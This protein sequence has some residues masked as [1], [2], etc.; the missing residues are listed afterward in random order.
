[1]TVARATNNKN[2]KIKVTP[3]KLTDYQKT[4]LN[5]PQ[6]FSVVEA[7]TKTGKTFSHIFWLFRLAHGLDPVWYTNNVK[8]GQNYWWIAPV[9]SQ[10]KIAFSR[11]KRIIGNAPG[12]KFNL[13]DLIVITPKQTEIHFKS[14]DNPDNLYGEDV[15]GVVFDEF[16]RAK[17]SAW[18]AL[19]STVTYTKAPVK[20]IGNYTGQSNW[21]HKLTKKAITDPTEYAAFRV[22]A[23]DA[24]KAGILDEKEIDQA[25]QDLPLSIFTALYLAE[26]VADDSVLFPEKALEDMFSN[27]FVKEIGQKYITADIALHGSDRFVIQVWHG[28]VVIAT[29]VVDKCNADEVEAL[30]REKAMLHGV[31]QR[32]IAY[33]ADG[34]GAFLK[35]YLKSAIPFNNGAAPIQDGKT[36]VNY[37]HLKAQ[38]FYLLAK[39][40]QEN[41]IYIK[42]TE[43]KEQIILE[44]ENIRK[45]NSDQDGKLAV[46]PK[47]AMKELL[48]FSPDFAESL[49]MRMAFE[50][51]GKKFTSMM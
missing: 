8:P 38:C 35:G 19:R 42:S 12:Y 6:R 49:M 18:F 43:F 39:A 31:A 3:P 5:C 2:I 28:W 51:P 47:K 40:I 16:T 22:T 33:D 46:T 17:Q 23:Y 21:G 1:M 36:K 9:Y 25:R 14:A 7:S 50:L 10:A 20:F 29:Y 45:Y 13:S 32:N 41:R 26:G 24:V 15:Y 4:F 44:L 48:G 37:Q 34:V 11:M 27:S 30:L